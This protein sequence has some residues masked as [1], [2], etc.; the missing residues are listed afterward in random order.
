[1]K[2]CPKCHGTMEEGRV[3]QSERALEFINVGE[4]KLSRKNQLRSDTIIP[5]YCTECGYI[6]LYTKRKS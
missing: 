5:Y 4:V 6:E 2:H 3:L 1:M